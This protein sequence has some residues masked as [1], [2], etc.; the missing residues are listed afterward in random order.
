MCFEVQGDVFTY[1]LHRA[2]DKEGSRNFHSNQLSGIDTPF[3]GILFVDI[4]AHRPIRETKGVE[5]CGVGHVHRY[6]SVCVNSAA[7]GTGNIGIVTAAR[8]HPQHER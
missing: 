7:A 5:G 4:E 2:I 3:P 1:V 6:E 8:A